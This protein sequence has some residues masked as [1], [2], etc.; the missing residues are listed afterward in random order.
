[1]PIKVSQRVVFLLVLLR[2]ICVKRAVEIVS[3]ENINPYEWEE[4]KKEAG[5]RKVITL[6][7]EEEREEIATNAII[8]GADDQFI[9]DI[10]GLTLERI[11]EIRTN[12][13]QK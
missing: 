5:R 11:T 9:A 12:L 3:Y 13:A 4:S 2:A 6:E 10:T 1:V 7:R 8:K